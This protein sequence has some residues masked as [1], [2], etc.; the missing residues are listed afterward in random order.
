MESK[1][2]FFRREDRMIQQRSQEKCSSPG[3]LGRGGGRIGENQTGI[4]DRYKSIYVF[5]DSIFLP[6][7]SASGIS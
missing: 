1:T 5:R 4:P 6:R 7:V 3:G 2:T